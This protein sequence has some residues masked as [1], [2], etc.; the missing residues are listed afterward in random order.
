MGHPLWPL[1]DLRLRTPALELRLPSEDELVAL[2]GVARAGVHDPA[3]MPFTVPWTDQPSPQFEREFLKFHWGVRS[4]WSPENWTLGLAVFHAGEPMGFQDL[5]AESFAVLRGVHTGSWLGKRFHGRG[6]GKQM[7]AAVL[8]LAFAELGAV[9][10]HSG[11][12]AD[13]AASV[14]VSRAL[15]YEPNGVGRKA[16]RGEPRDFLDLRLTR[17]R[18]EA[19]R[20]CEVEVAGLDTCREMFGID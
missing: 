7:R 4:R 19:R 12:F 8:H 20:H 13:N 3:D 9:A 11:V 1:Y 10:A 2:C 5:A 14:G 6:Y 15:G 17:E 18:W 16:P